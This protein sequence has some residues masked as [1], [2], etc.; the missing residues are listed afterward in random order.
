MRGDGWLSD[1]W[2]GIKSAAKYVAKPVVKAIRTAVVDPAAQA[3]G[4]L[5][6]SINPALG[7]LAQQ[8]IYKASDFAASKG[9]ARRRLAPKRRVVRRSG[10]RLKLAVMP[11]PIGMARRR[12]AAPKRRVVRRRIGASYQ[13]L[14]Y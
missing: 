10:G 4:Q 12:R 1:A 3:A 14:L 9:Y 6:G 13:Q 5:V 7:R 8:G 2:S 11:G